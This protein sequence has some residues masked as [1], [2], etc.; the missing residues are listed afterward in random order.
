MHKGSKVGNSVASPDI[1]IKMLLDKGCAS[2]VNAEIKST[3]EKGVSSTAPIFDKI[4]EYLL[5]AVRKT[6]ISSQLLKQFE[7]GLKAMKQSNFSEELIRD[8]DRITAAGTRFGEVL[9]SQAAAAAKAI[10]EVGEANRKLTQGLDVHPSWNNA[11]VGKIW[12]LHHEEWGGMQNAENARRE[13]EQTAAADRAMQQQNAEAELQ[14]R[15]TNARAAAEALQRI[16][17]Q[18][19]EEKRQRIFGHA[20]RYLREDGSAA[21]LAAASEMQRVAAIK[22]M[23]DRARGYSRQEMTESAAQEQQRLQNIASMGQRAREYS[24]K[25]IAEEEARKQRLQFNKEKQ[26][27]RRL[28]ERAGYLAAAGDPEAAFASMDLGTRNQ[29]LHPEDRAAAKAERDLARAERAQAL[30]DSHSA[31]ERRYRTMERGDRL[32]RQDAEFMNWRSVGP[33]DATASR[34]GQANLAV[35][36]FLLEQYER[37]RTS[38]QGGGP[39]NSHNFRFATQQVGFGIDDAIQSYHYGGFSASARAAS[40]NLTA[41]AG[42]GIANPAIAA[43]TVVGLSVATAALPLV[44]KHAGFDK[45][46]YNAGAAGRYKVDSTGAGALARGDSPMEYLSQSSGAVISAMD[47]NDTQNELFMQAH[48]NL[49]KWKKLGRTFPVGSF[50]HRRASNFMGKEDAAEFDAAY[51]FLDNMEKTAPQKKAELQVKIE[52][53]RKDNNPAN[54][55]ILEGVRTAQTAEEAYRKS[56]LN[57]GDYENSIRRTA[58]A[59]LAGIPANAHPLVREAKTAMIEMQMQDALSRREENRNAVKANLYR[60]WD[61]YNDYGSGNQ[62]EGIRSGFLQRR[63][64]IN[65]DASLTQEQHHRLTELNRAR[66]NLESGRSFE[67][68]Q[69]SNLNYTDPIAAL[70]LARNRRMEDYQRSV[71]AGLMDP[72]TASALMHSNERG[73]AEQRARIV[74]DMTHEND[75]NNPIGK[76]AHQ[77][78]RAS[79]DLQKR[80][81]EGNYTAEEQATME[82]NLKRNYVL[83]QRELNKPHGTERFTSDA[84]IVGSAADNELRARMLGVFAPQDADDSW[85]KQ[86]L[87]EMAETAKNTENINRKLEL[88]RLRLK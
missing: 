54:L 27:Y 16:R 2:Q 77:F 10:A 17:E 56:A 69:R 12:R 36:D 20:A 23:G 59:Q 11:R 19:G 3:L 14:Q 65:D 22:A 42:M 33:V 52:K 31:S 62:L 5:T 13:Q 81:R 6:D 78:S 61:M 28:E 72:K 80:F 84:N 34:R 64:A 48:K 30:A 21:S 87:K 67:D 83:Q 4:E 79:E 74:D 25:D 41:I 24:R 47:E 38:R 60:S 53:M 1:I 8:F 46:D 75:I 29:Q 49:G 39:F 76:L 35:R 58:Q 32:L 82:D 85:K 44:L 70:E 86:S 45:I 55:A 50:M 73:F 40:N 57:L 63:R 68:Q 9:I 37:P 18:E 71:A 51:A 7:T 26:Q 88:T 43:A 66:F 15:R